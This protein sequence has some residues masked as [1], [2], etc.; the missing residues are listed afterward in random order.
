MFQHLNDGAARQ[1]GFGDLARGLERPVVV[2]DQPHGQETPD[3]AHVHPSVAE[4]IQRAAG[5]IGA[6]D[7]QRDRFGARKKDPRELL[8]AR[9]V[10]DPEVVAELLGLV[11]EV[12][13]REKEND[14]RSRDQT[15]HREVLFL[16]RVGSVILDVAGRP[17]SGSRTRRG[18]RT[19]FS[20]PAPRRRSSRSPRTGR[21]PWSV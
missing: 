15:H 7:V 11:D 14:R 12:L 3:D 2:L 4:E 5:I 21:I 10:G 8:L 20:S 17:S 1:Q 6:F 19:W 18:G 16:E 13:V 9:R